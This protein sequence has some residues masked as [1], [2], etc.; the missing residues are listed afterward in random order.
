MAKPRVYEIAKEL[1][2]DSKTALEKLKDMGEFV[3][4]ASSTVEPPVARKLRSAF[5]KQGG[6]GGQGGN[7]Q[8]GAGSHGAPKGARPGQHH[9]SPAP[10]PGPAASH[11]SRTSSAAPTPGPRPAAPAAGASASA[12]GEHEQHPVPGARPAAPR[13]GQHRPGQSG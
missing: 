9:P 13:P 3:K 8:N 1:G 5:A 2:I 7:R 12:A 11:T 6:N 10:T 4:S